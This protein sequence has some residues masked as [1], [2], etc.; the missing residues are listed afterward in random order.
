MHGW[1]MEEGHKLLLG[2]LSPIPK[3]LG[4]LISTL[5]LGMYPLSMFCPLLSLAVVLYSADKYFCV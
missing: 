1:E 5:E 2:G 3:K 4:N